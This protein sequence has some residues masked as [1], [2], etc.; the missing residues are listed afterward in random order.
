MILEATTREV[1]TA[2]AKAVQRAL[3]SRKHGHGRS[4]QK[5]RDQIEA[6]SRMSSYVQ[7]LRI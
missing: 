6:M 7:V 1:N 5:A 4:R 2:K 3:A